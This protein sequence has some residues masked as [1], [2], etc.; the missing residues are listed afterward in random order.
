M[1]KIL[2]LILAAL[3][4]L[5]TLS[6]AFAEELP[7]PVFG[8]LTADD[9]EYDPDPAYEK[10][11]VLEYYIE[12]ADAT[13]VVTCSAKLDN[14][15]FSM[16]YSFYGDDQKVVCNAAGE[17]SYDKTGFMGG[18]RTEEHTSELQ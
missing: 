16:E 14:S 7:V 6:V 5:G 1:K 12:N 3:V 15:E 9:A 11:T 2:A 10:Y 8:D 13:V 4:L 18:D 17:V